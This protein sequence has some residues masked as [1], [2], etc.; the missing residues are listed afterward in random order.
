VKI[1]VCQ[2]GN[3]LFF[4]NT[5]CLQC[6]RT[7]GYC[8]DLGRLAALE[9]AGPGLWSVT[10]AGH[11]R[12][13]SNYAREDVCN[14]MVPA[15]DPDPFCRACRLNEIIPDLS[16]PRH[17]EYWRRIEAAKRHMLY[18][19]YQLRLPVVSRRDDPQHGLAFTF[20]ADRDSDTEFTDPIHGQDTVLTGHRAGVITINLAEADDV[21]RARMRE[22]LQERYRTLLGHFRHE[23]GH[24]YWDRLVRDVPERLAE[25]RQIFSD[26]RRDYQGALA[27]H[28]RQGPPP[29]WE[30]YY[31]SSYAS[32]HPWE[33]WAETWAHYMHMVDTLET[34]QV[35]GIVPVGRSAPEYADTAFNPAHEDFTVLLERWVQLTVTMNAIN[36]SMGLPDAY[37][38]VLQPTAQDKLHFIHRLIAGLNGGR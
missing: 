37:P 22:Q 33:D 23:I 10:G 30:Q 29:D 21:A 19:L 12:Q 17:R 24:Y 25:F 11:Y 32:V 6:G 7:L 26:E 27:L 15:A 4:S 36:H 38:F 2:C 20:L 14:W 34:A 28:Y 1:F 3:T 13:C 9:A 18:T 16:R 35:F 8:P 5:R 31:I